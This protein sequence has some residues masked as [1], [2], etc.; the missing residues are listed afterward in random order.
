MMICTCLEELK[1]LRLKHLLIDIWRW[2]YRWISSGKTEG[3]TLLL[4]S[5]HAFIDNLS[6]RSSIH[7]SSYLSKRLNSLSW[8]LGRSLMLWSSCC[9]FYQTGQLFSGKNLY[10]IILHLLLHVLLI[11]KILFMV[12]AARVLMLKTQ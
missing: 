2:L 12:D 3:V 10:K 8:I 9:L 11:Q 6:G 4:L 1:N 7:A 5:C